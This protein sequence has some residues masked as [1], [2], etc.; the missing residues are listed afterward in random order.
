MNDQLSSRR[1]PKMAVAVYWVAVLL[2]LFGTVAGQTPPAQ[3]DSK[4]EQLKIG[5]NLVTAGVIVT[6]RYG[7]FIPGL[8]RGDFAVREDGKPQKIEDFSS[9][10]EAFNVALLIDTSRSTQN[11]LSSIRKAAQA[12]IKQL[13]PN[14][15]VMIVGFDEKVTFVTDFT[16]NRAELERA[17]KS[18]KSSYLTRLY[19]A[20][21]MTVNDKMKAMP[22]RK[23]I[24]VLT[25]GVDRS[26]RLAT[27]ESAL[28]S[29]SNAGIIT[30]TIQYETRN[31]GGPVSRPLFQPRFGNSF[32]GGAS[33]AIGWAQDP[34]REEK[35]PIIN[36]PPPSPSILSEPRTPP[37]ERPSTRVNQQAQQA[38][39][40]PYLIAFEFL[41]AVAVQSG[42]LHLRAESIESTTYQFQIIAA[43]LRNQYTL[44]YISTNDQ[45][46]GK[47]RT[48]AVGVRNPDLVVRTR[49][50]YRIPL[51]D[52]ADAEKPSIP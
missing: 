5:T 26:S 27:F 24:V 40:D 10:E 1:R 28:E 50:G 45:R 38:L 39:R 35:K 33:K 18:L 41:H 44:T 7:R 16:N 22:G 11:K 36:L 17:V 52:P 13:Q 19:D 46:D 49:L 20:I 12:F 3:T 47:Y 42:A 32:V 34:S 15:R 23:A 2:S 21:Q 8:S 6:D 25:D 31:D 48:I 14:D 30:Y 9:T 51:A 4:E 37:G 29:V 43:E